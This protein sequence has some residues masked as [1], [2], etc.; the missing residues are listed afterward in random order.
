M[1]DIPLSPEKLHQPMAEGAA[2]GS[3]ALE[4]QSLVGFDSATRF[5]YIRA[6]ARI[7][8]EP[9]R[10]C[11]TRDARPASNRRRMLLRLR[12]HRHSKANVVADIWERL[13]EG[14]IAFMNSHGVGSD[15]GHDP[16][17]SGRQRGAAAS[18]IRCL[19]AGSSAPA[20]RT[21]LLPT[22]DNCGGRVFCPGPSDSVRIGG[23]SSRSP[24]ILPYPARIKRLRIPAGS[25]KGGVSP[26]SQSD[27]QKRPGIKLVPPRIQPT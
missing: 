6:A 18:F 13:V 9:Q 21:T 27:R 25:T 11:V 3:N 2:T 20:W 8:A 5:G 16:R 12:A 22:C 26:S 14:S 15:K 19:M 10:K 17:R 7:K 24:S 1:N 23:Q 4:S